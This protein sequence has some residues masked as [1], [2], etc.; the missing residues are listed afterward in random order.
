M[1]RPLVCAVVLAVLAAAGC[2]DRE[3]RASPAAG[4]PDKPEA[5]PGRP[6]PTTHEACAR[7]ALPPADKLK[8]ITLAGVRLVPE[9]FTLKPASGQKLPAKPRLLL[10]VLADTHHADADFHR[11]QRQPRTKDCPDEP[12]L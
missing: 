9:G 11:A 8:E 7:L 5:A 3:D 6:L 10:G 12:W 1:T 4:K 2:P